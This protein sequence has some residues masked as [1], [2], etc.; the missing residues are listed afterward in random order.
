[1]ERRDR[2][3]TGPWHYLWWLV[4]SQ[5]RRV[6]LGAL[7]GSTWMVGLT[8]PPLVLSLAID[9]GLE[10]GLGAK[11]WGWAGILGGVGIGIAV[12]AILRHRTMTKVRIYA[13]QQ[14]IRAVATQSIGLGSSLQRQAAAGEVAAIGVS[15]AWTMARSLTVTGPGVGAVVAYVVIAA[16]LLRISPL[17]AV[18]ILI[19]AP[20]LLLL[21]GPV[22]NRFRIHGTAYR[23]AEGELSGRI[24]DIVSGLRVLTTLGG[25]SLFAERW[26]V[27]SDLVR[28]TG[29]RLART[30]SWIRG[31]AVGLPALFLA[32]VMW[33]TARMTVQGDMSVGEFVAVFG[34]VAVVVVPVSF[35][36][37]AA[38]DINRAL[39]S[40]QRTSRFLSI[41]PLARGT[42][43]VNDA[44]A[45][46]S[47]PG[48][49]LRLEIGAFA[50]VATD[51]RHQAKAIM[52]R[53]AGI[54][55]SDARW[56]DQPLAEIDPTVLRRAVLPLDDGDYLF[57]GPLR[58]VV[59][60]NGDQGDAERERVAY[61]S[62]IDEMLRGFDDGW[63]TPIAERGVN[64]SA[65]QRQR[66]RLARALAAGPAVLLALDPL[67]AVDA[68]TESQVVERVRDARRGLTTLVF[69]SSATVL[70]AA[71]VVHLVEEGR[72]VASGTHASLVASN[73][74]YRKLV[75][76]NTSEEDET[77]R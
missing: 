16:A 9:E 17:L 51:D 69:S 55:T 30:E 36:I 53:L 74:R 73:G 21:L 18:V 52:E 61:A 72:T 71:D 43:P 46:L 45:A 65:G 38:I 31:V 24:V 49:G 60:T 4:R 33:L 28:R 64:L 76:R 14:T 58:D 57:A 75:S 29:Y 66:L 54:E 19:G 41:E 50:V 23:K 5:W 12:L 2:Y 59:F 62:G 27:E 35:F 48:S 25:K 3:S 34:Y 77:S 22:L 15:D 63:A 40:A 8:V 6:L 13:A 26:E 20:A 68:V 1:M 44:T 37:E 47:D 42:A 11:V 39:V 70:A 56:G 67:S 7:L 32:I 10:Y